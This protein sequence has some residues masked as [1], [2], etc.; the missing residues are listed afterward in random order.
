[1]LAGLYITNNLPLAK[2][3]F[4]R[5]ITKNKIY[6]FIL[7]KSLKYRVLRIERKLFY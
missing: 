4:K 5:R 7:N 2:S 3:N 6:L 1:M